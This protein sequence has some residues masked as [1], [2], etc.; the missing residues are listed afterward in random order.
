M[1]SCKF[2]MDEKAQ[3]AIEMLLLIGGVVL[4]ALV[5]GIYLKSIPGQLAPEIEA[6]GENIASGM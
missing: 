1:R 5:V 2:A 6:A 4:V 3:G